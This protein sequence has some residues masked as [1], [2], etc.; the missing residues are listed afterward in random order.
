MM[1]V[2]TAYVKCFRLFSLCIQELNILFFTV[3]TVPQIEQLITT[4]K[5]GRMQYNTHPG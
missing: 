5:Y 1:L 4:N 2:G 3:F